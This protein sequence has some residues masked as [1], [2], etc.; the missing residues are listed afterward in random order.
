M[1][2]MNAPNVTI[3]PCAKFDS[4]VVPKMSDSPIEVMRDDHRQLQPV[5]ERLR[6]QAPLALDVAGSSPR[7]NA[8]VTF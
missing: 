1:N 2:A 4:P 8:R 5:G 3:S 7:K 6:Q